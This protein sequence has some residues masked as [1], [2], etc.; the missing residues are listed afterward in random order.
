MRPSGVNSVDAGHPR[1]A[2]GFGCP[3]SV[4]RGRKQVLCKG[5]LVSHLGVP[6]VGIAEGFR[7]NE[8]EWECLVDFRAPV[9]FW[10]KLSELQICFEEMFLNEGPPPNKRPRVATKL[11]DADA[12][13]SKWVRE[14]GPSNVILKKPSLERFLQEFPDL[15]KKEGVD[16]KE[17]DLESLLDPQLTYDVNKLYVREEIKRLKRVKAIQRGQP[18]IRL[19]SLVTHPNVS[20]IGVV[21]GFRVN[22]AGERECLVDF[23]VPVKIWLKVRELL[24]C[25]KDTIPENPPVGRESDKRNAAEPARV[26]RFQSLSP[27]R[28]RIVKIVASVEPRGLTVP[29]LT[30]ELIR[31]GIRTSRR[32]VSGTTKELVEMGWLVREGEGKTFRVRLSEQAKRIIPPTVIP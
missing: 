26:L 21:I 6:E 7:F 8:G 10:F 16:P 11:V 24:V 27:H 25:P 31:E 32:S 18:I 2:K 29:E 15:C 4:F 1:Y 9:K 17:I 14:L 5:D 13:Y 22:K 20:E 28:K 12:L 3:N 23:G 30:R 19:G